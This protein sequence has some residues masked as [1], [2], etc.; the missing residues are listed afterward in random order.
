MTFT[1]TPNEP[2]PGETL[3]QSQPI[4]NANFQY[5]MSS[6]SVGAL[7]SDHNMTLTHPNTADGYHKIIHFLNQGSDPAGVATTGQLYTKTINS[8]QELVFESGTANL[9]S[10]LTG[11]FKNGDGSTSAQCSGYAYIMG[12]IIVQWGVLPAV[13]GSSGLAFTFGN[14]ATTKCI[15]FPNQCFAIVG[16]PGAHSTFGSFSVGRVG[17]FNMSKTGGTARFDDGGTSDVFFVAI[18]N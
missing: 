10:Q 12:Q 15:A 5:L 18:G 14:T 8:N 6:S 2:Q 17:F 3:A 11:A 1:Y 13:P 16:T 9:I 7:N 4:I